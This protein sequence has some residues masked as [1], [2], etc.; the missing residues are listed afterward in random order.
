MPHSVFLF[1]AFREFNEKR[2]FQY[3]I[4]NI[5]IEHSLL[6]RFR[7][8]NKL[9]FDTQ[10]DHPKNA[11]WNRALSSPLY[12]WGRSLCEQKLLVQ[13][14]SAYSRQRIDKTGLL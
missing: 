1:T 6:I 5:S 8:E 13:V 11:E 14:T 3:S 10:C 4:M 9:L 2:D 12:K 7:L